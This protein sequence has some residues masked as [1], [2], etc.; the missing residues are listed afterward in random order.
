MYSE[1]DRH[2]GTKTMES[3]DQ[4][5]LEYR[6]RFAH[7]YDEHNYNTGLQGFVMRAGH[8]L[9]EKEVAQ[10]SHLGTILEVGAGTGEHFPYIR[11]SFDTYI[12][13]DLDEQALQVAKR[14]AAGLSVAQTPSFL[15]QRAFPLPYADGTF[16]RL[17]ACNILEHL[18]SPHLVLKEWRR[19]LK[20]GGLLSVLIPTDPGMAWRLGRALSN[21]PKLRAQGIPYDY[22]MAREH[23]NACTNLVALLRYYFP[24]SR[25]RWWP[26]GV[27]AV[28]L[29]LFVAFH[30]VVG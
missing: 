21:R 19:V 4:D 14:K 15:A 9:L 2:E 12:M 13:T 29:N 1:A 8:T 23:I 22:I 30:A 27:R 28:D 17:I 10:N 3:E 7:V 18:P 26:L 11:H 25:E 20:P 24:Q 16:D 6:Q 5:W